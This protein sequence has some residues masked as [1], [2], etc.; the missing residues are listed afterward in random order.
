MFEEKIIEAL[1]NTKIKT[2]LIVYDF[3]GTLVDTQMP[4]TGKI[5]WKEKTGNDWPHIGWWSKP[6]SLSTEVFDQPLISSVVSAYKKHILEPNTMNIMLTGRRKEVAK[7]VQAILDSYGLK[8]DAY[9][10]NYGGETADN[11]MQQLEGLLKNN[12]TIQSVIMYDDR[13]EHIPRFQAWGDNLVA[14]GVIKKF[15]INHVLGPHHGETP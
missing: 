5:I 14:K 12:P 2:E 7:Q 4:E 13:D 9:M 11:K 15:K 1:S 6:E 3:D 10:Y 8:F